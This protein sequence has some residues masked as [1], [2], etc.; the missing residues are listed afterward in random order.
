[1]VEKETQIESIP[2]GITMTHYGPGEKVSSQA[3][4]FYWQYWGHN[5]EPSQRLQRLALDQDYVL[6]LRNSQQIIAIRT[7]TLDGL[8]GF[9][10]THP[11]HLR[12]GHSTRLVLASIDVLQQSNPELKDITLSPVTPEG[13][14]FASRILDTVAQQRPGVTP[15]IKMS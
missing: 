4:K 14:K 10:L 3:F 5:L 2:N 15:W 7:F 11:D 12:Q 6:S 1:M 9:S 13:V 8:N